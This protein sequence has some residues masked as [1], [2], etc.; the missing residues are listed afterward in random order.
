M[1]KVMYECVVEEFKKE[2]RMSFGYSVTSETFSSHC[3]ICTFRSRPLQF[4]MI[5]LVLLNEYL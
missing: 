4:V 5:L 1:S 3:Y 2:Q